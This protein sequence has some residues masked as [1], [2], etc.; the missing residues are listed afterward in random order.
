MPTHLNR[1]LENGPS[2]E[3]GSPTALPPFRV[4]DSVPT[5]ERL[6]PMVRRPVAATANA[7]YP[8]QL[9]GIGVP[10]SKTARSTST[11]KKDKAVKTKTKGQKLSVYDS[12]LETLVPVASILWALVLWGYSIATINP[13]QM[14][15][16]GLVSVLP[17]TAYLAI[18]L[19]TF[20][21]TWTLHQGRAP[22]WLLWLHVAS[23]VFMIHGAP[24]LVY[25]TL[26]YSWAWKHLG[27]IDYIQRHGFVDPNASSLMIYHNWPGF[28]SFFAYLFDVA[29]IKDGVALASWAPVFFNLIEIGALAL[30]F[31]ASTNDRRL[32]WQGIWFYF[33]TNW[34]G[35]EYFSPQALNYFLHLVIIGICL[36]WFR[37]P[38]GG[39]PERLHHK[40]VQPFYDAL[41]HLRQR[42]AST[43]SQALNAPAVQRS[44]LLV[45]MIVLFVVIA[46][47]HQ[48][49]P[50]VTVLAIAALVFFRRCSASSLP[51][52]MAVM[53]VTWIIYG[54]SFFVRDELFVL[55][56]S[57]GTITSNIGNNLLD[58]SNVTL[59]QK[60]VAYAGRSLTM[61]VMLLA[62][63]GCLVRIRRGKWD[64]SLMLLA[65][66]PFL[67][68]L[69]NGYGGEVVFR[70]YLFALPFLAFFMAALLYPTIERG[71]SAWTVVSNMVLSLLLF[72]GFNLAYYGKDQ[73]Y[74]FTSQEVEASQ[75]LYEHAP[76]NSLLIEGSRNYPS[77]F[78]NYENFT[79]VPL[80]REKPENQANWLEDPVSV[81]TRWMRNTEYNAAFL[82]LTRSQRAEVDARLTT[83]PEGALNKIEAAL[84]AS[85][86]FSVV[87]SN[88]DAVIF[89]LTERLDSVK[90]LQTAA[91]AKGG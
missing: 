4:A 65:F 29:G 18:V 52:L 50:I 56:K 24:A 73:M 39:E 88:Q 57:F 44:G 34:V 23:F 84:R 59:G 89:T 26:R 32:V 28:F 82:V 14:T 49:T 86:Q 72:A 41:H 19:L 36:A 53:M 66:A 55:F 2:G 5:G 1:A 8:Q 80:S 67:L 91:M 37:T 81:F 38:M 3:K 60:I 63:A 16:L 83:L 31:R 17:N 58:L 42:A 6:L 35:Q 33:L 70:V 7:G 69:G 74:F 22:T 10:T 62:L 21:F 27:I 76:A 46:T 30:I 45:M 71:N 12:W 9:L 51:M 78:R 64:L 48:L 47:S 43:D 61:A 77:Q 15:D 85:P 11:R 87:Y 68:L 54:A 20:S 79:Y 90:A 13:L 40:L 25:D 75:F